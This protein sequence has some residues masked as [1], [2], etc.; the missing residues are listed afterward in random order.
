SFLKNSYEHEYLDDFP[1]RK[2]KI[3]DKMDVM[4]ANPSH[5]YQQFLGI[6][7]YDTEIYYHL[8]KINVHDDFRVFSDDS[9]TAVFDIMFIFIESEIS[10][11]RDLL[12][13][14]LEGIES[15]FDKDQEL[16]DT[17]FTLEGM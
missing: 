15:L 7:T 17:N 16:S 3:V 1:T 6:F 14:I 2:D 5:Y 13:S 8:T 12:Q 11:M 9:F 4:E 10:K